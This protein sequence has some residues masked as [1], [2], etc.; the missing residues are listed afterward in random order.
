[1][2]E[3]CK[4]KEIYVDKKYTIENKMRV[5]V[6]RKAHQIWETNRKE[7]VPRGDTENAFYFMKKS[8]GKTKRKKFMFMK[9]IFVIQ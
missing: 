3:C 9:G 6:K 1:M 7:N 2:G 8:Q 5:M 4:K